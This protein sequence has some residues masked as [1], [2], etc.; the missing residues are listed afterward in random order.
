ME[1]INILSKGETIMDILK[2]IFGK[3]D[4]SELIMKRKEKEKSEQKPSLLK[5]VI[6]NPESFKLEAF[7]EN[8][9]IIVKVKRRES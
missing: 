6:E 7:I 3:L 9:E 8:D 2:A 4:I 1:I 5:D